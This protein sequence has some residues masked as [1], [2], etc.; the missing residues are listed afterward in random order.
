MFLVGNF[1]HEGHHSHGHVV[2]GSLIGAFLIAITII[3]TLIPVI[4]ISILVGVSLTGFSLMSYVLSV[5]FAVEYSVHIVSRWMRAD[6]SIVSNVDRIDHTM[7]FLML[8]TIMSFVSSTIGVICLSF[9]DFEFNDVFFF[10]PLI[11]VMFM[12]YWMGCWFLPVVLFYLDMDS[13]KMGIPAS[14]AVHGSAKALED[15]EEEP[16]DDESPDVVASD[17]ADEY[18]DTKDADEVSA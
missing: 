14:D 6:M 13:V 9:T 1:L 17:A 11:I 15:S 2:V 18:A 8:P 3:F 7:S 12:S 16:Q 4:G 5:G 10:R